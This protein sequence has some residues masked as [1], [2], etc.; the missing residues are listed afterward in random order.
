MSPRIPRP[1]SVPAA[2]PAAATALNHPNICTIHEIGE[3]RGRPFIVM[4][5]L[6]GRTLQETI[7]GRPLETDRL[8]D[9]G[10]E[11]ADAL[12]AVHAKGIVHRD[13]KPA[14]PPADP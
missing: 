5:P 9:L 4:E 7:F 10:I 2:K 11:I 1:G 14:N 13:I 12:D 8:V 3:F 6:E